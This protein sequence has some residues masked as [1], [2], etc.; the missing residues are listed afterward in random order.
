MQQRV[1]HGS[2][3]VAGC[4]AMF[5]VL[6][7]P[8]VATAQPATVPVATATRAASAAS[9]GVAL[10][11]ATRAPSAVA[12]GAGGGVVQATP[13]RSPAPAVIPATGNPADGPNMGLVIALA[14]AGL[15]A[16]VGLATRLRPQGRRLL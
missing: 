4:L 9:G 2:L 12:T 1:S 16:A 5:L 8:Q 6:L 14:I 15:L 11:T 3:C 10:A 7:V 13:T